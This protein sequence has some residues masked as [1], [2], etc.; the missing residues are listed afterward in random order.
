[1]AVRVDSDHRP[2]IN[3]R[4]NV[5]GWPTT[6]FLTGHGG[7]IGGAT[8]LG[9]G[10]V[11]RHAWRRCREAYQEDR[12]KVYEHALEML[13]LRKEQVGRVVAGPEIVRSL[14]DRAARTVAGAYDASN[15]GFGEEPKFPNTPILALLIHLG[16]HN[17]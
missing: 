14:L 3:A 6:A 10:P 1:M 5:G 17:R 16:A 11:P 4:Y 7:F 13:R 15:G 8:Y 12:P 9:T 2:D